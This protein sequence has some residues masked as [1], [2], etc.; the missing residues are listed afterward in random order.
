MTESWETCRG[1]GLAIADRV[2]S[3][4]D[5]P[6]QPP[7]DRTFLLQHLRLEVAIDDVAKTVSGT[8]VHRLAPINDGLREVV[9]DAQDL[10]IRK[11]TDGEGTALTW[12]H[13]GEALTIRLPRP[14]RAGQ[15]FELRIRYDAKPRKGLYFM[16]PDKAYPDRPRIVWRPA[17]SSAGHVSSSALFTFC[18][19]R[20]GPSAWLP[21]GF[22]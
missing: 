5:A 1:H 17:R 3:A 20:T 6:P 19:D 18:S 9:L 11:V 7:R 12:D 4:P 10:T 16:A 15:A 2:F 13:R 8:A 14:K 21:S 22:L